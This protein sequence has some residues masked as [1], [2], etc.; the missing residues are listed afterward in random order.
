MSRKDIINESFNPLDFIEGVSP[1]F[2]LNL[3]LRKTVLEKTINY[4]FE[5]YPSVGIVRL[6]ELVKNVTEMGSV[7]QKELKDDLTFQ[8]S[9]NISIYKLLVE[10][11]GITKT[12]LDYFKGNINKNIFF[13]SLLE[14]Y[15]SN[16][17]R[18]PIKDELIKL[19]YGDEKNFLTIKFDGYLSDKRIMDP[20]LEKYVKDKKSPTKSFFDRGSGL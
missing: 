19:A 18:V 16:E 5:E 4:T 2:V 6:V 20:N 9:K 1:N 12:Y 14:I 8:N 11:D 13:S 3:A 15:V 10:V 17:E 7:N